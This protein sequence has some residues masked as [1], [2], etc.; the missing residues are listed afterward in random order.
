MMIDVLAGQNHFKSAL[1]T[2]DKQIKRL[3][4]ELREREST[5]PNRPRLNLINQ[6][7]ST[8]LIDKES[9]IRTERGHANSIPRAGLRK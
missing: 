3:W 8:T 7:Q 5:Y 9:K 1:T 4:R 6:H 2:V